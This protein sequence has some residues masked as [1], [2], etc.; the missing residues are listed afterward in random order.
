MHIGLYKINPQFPNKQ[1]LKGKRKILQS[2][3]SKLRNQYNIAIAEVDN[4]D[5]GQ[6]EQKPGRIAF[7]F[8]KSGS[9]FVLLE[10]CKEI[11]A[12]W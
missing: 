2:I 8:E 12:G 6:I 10:Q 9:N 11:I 4:N 1:T 5:S 7:F 3:I